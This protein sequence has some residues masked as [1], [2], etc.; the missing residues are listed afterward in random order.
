MGSAKIKFR[1]LHFQD[2]IVHDDGIITEHSM[3][4]P[5][6]VGKLEQ[7]FKATGIRR[8]ESRNYIAAL[9]SRRDL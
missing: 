4:D 7:T 3:L 5:Q 1:H 8:A 6:H 9:I 2:R